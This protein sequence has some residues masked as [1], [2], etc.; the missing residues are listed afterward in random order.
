LETEDYCHKLRLKIGQNSQKAV[1]ARVGST[2][3]AGL[4]TAPLFASTA[5]AQAGAAVTGGSFL[6]LALQ[7]FTPYHS[8]AGGI[9]LGVA[10]AM[11]MLT[12]GQVLGIS[13]VVG[14]RN[15]QKFSL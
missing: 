11:S 9:I 1:L 15:S 13:G 5:A 4:L 10:T 14:G 2:L 3:V 8:A 6:G 7:N 12:R